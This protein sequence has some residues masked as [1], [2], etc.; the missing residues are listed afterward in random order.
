MSDAS[1]FVEPQPTPLAL[2]LLGQDSD[3]LSERGVECP[4]ALPMP[5]D[6]DLVERATVARAA[7]S[8]PMPKPATKSRSSTTLTTEETIR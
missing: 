5:S 7:P 1:T 6:P 8:T 2:L 3:A 4:G